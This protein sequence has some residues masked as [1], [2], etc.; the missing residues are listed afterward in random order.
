MSATCM[1][2]VKIFVPVQFSNLKISTDD[3]L[4]NKVDYK[5]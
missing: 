4:I 1:V 3:V 5:A 2:A